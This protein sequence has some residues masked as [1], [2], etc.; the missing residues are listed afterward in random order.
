MTE[1]Y[2]IIEEKLDLPPRRL[3]RVPHKNR[4]LTLGFPAFGPDGYNS[5]LRE[6]QKSYA[7]PLTGDKISFRG[8]VTSESISATVYKFGT[9]AKPSILDPSWL[10]LGK[11]VRTSDGVYAN[12]PR[13]N[14]IDSE[15]D[16]K[17]LKKLIDKSKKI[18]VGK[19]Y[20]YL[21]DNDFGFADYQSFE[22]GVQDCDTF[23]QGGLARILECTEREAESLRRIASP[24]NYS[25][26]VNVWRFDAVN[27]PIVR[28]A[29]L[30]SG[31]GVGRGRLLVDGSDW[32]G[33]YVGF[34]FGVL[35]SGEASAKK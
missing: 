16:E 34:V 2:G 18:E 23:A 22:Q 29:G 33:S 10:Q 13:D 1:E 30:G 3:L 14:F 6:L 4:V 26:G 8:P 5:N 28:V 27:K 35:N 17:A 7:H 21:G 12:V 19:G 15:T 20:I 11:I 32:D 25:R 24:K 31:R 9:L